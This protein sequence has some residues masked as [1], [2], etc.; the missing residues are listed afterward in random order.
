L[1]GIVIE[2]RPALDVIQQYDNPTTLFYIDPPY[3]HRVRSHKWAK[4]AYQHDLTDDDHRDLA[5][6]LHQV[7]GMVMIS[8]YPCNLYRNLYGDWDRAE[9]RAMA[10]AAN[11][12]VEVLWMNPNCRNTRPRL[13]L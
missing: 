7:D 10:D 2:N 11:E 12:K 13:N 3:P 5:A 1:R 8:C 4:Y 9:R 6:A